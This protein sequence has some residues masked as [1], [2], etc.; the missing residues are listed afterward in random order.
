[1]LQALLQPGADLRFTATVLGKDK[2]LLQ[3]QLATE[4]GE[5]V[6]ES[7]VREGLARLRDEAAEEKEEDALL[8]SPLLSDRA[9]A[10]LCG[11]LADQDFFPAGLLPDLVSLVEETV[12]SAGNLAVGEVGPEGEDRC[13]DILR[14]TVALG[15]TVIHTRWSRSQSWLGRAGAASSDSGIGTGALIPSAVT[16]NTI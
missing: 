3:L 14:R 1:M 11:R 8:A 13:R 16:A 12:A 2:N 6:A 15:V 7:M 5:D 10:G 9:V 4:H